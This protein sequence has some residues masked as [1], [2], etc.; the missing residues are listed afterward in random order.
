MRGPE[1]DVGRFALAA[2]ACDPDII[3]RVNADAP[4]LDAAFVDAMIEAMIAEDADFVMLAR[5]G[6]LHDGVD[7]MSRRA[8]DL[9]LAEARDDKVARE[10][11]TGWLN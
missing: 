11:V 8:L 7:P 3:V 9:M 4:L 5:R 1:D 2:E 10:H 6:A